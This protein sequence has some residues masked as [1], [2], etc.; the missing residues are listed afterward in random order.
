MQIYLYFYG[1]KN[2]KKWN[3]YFYLSK[4]TKCSSSLF[5][6][7]KVCGWFSWIKKDI[8]FHVCISHYW[9]SMNGGL[10]RLNAYMFVDHV[11]AVKVDSPHQVS[12]AHQ[13]E[14]DTDTKSQ[15]EV[16]TAIDY[17]KGNCLTF[18]ASSH[19]PSVFSGRVF[20]D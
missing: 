9:K 17:C 5:T 10:S 1:V 20:H 6:I 4:I 19:K 11:W 12:Y 15:G 14:T 13:K 2:S 18:C 7:V 3:C 16:F 8:D